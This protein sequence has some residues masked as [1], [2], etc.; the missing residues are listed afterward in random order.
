MPYDLS[1]YKIQ[2]GDRVSI[3]GARSSGGVSRH[4]REGVEIAR[5]DF[6]KGNTGT[7][8]RVWKMGVGNSPPWIIVIPDKEFGYGEFTFQVKEIHKLEP[9][10][11]GE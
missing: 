5:W 10:E 6:E 8:E 1:K 3:E 4:L 11:R 7:V 9:P 2:P